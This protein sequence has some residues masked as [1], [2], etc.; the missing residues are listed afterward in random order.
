MSRTKRIE[1]F[2]EYQFTPEE[3]TGLSQDLARD[4]AK[5]AELEDARKMAMSQFKA[6]IDACHAR[7][8]LNAEHIRTGK[9]MRMIDCEVDY[10]TPKPGKKTI[11]RTDT[12]ERL[13]VMNMDEWEKQDELPQI[14]RASCRER[15]SD[16][17]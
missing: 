5:M 16:Y 14:G 13:K 7:A 17:V 11:T 2:L 10:D 6:E 12:G 3:L 4:T 1:Q 15:V 9:E 8:N